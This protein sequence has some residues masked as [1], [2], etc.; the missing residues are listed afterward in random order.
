MT[1]PDKFSGQDHPTYRY[2][3]P[4]KDGLWGIYYPRQ[5]DD[6]D[7]EKWL[8]QLE[9]QKE[10]KAQRD[11]DQTIRLKAS[12]TES[13][14]DSEIRKIIGD[15]KN[16]HPA[17][18]AEILKRKGF[19]DEM[20]AASDLVYVE[21]YQKLSIKVNPDLAGVNEWGNGLTNNISGILC[22]TKNELGQ[23]TGWQIRDEDPNAD[24]RYKWASSGSE[25]NKK[26]SHLKNG[27]L[28]LSVID[29]GDRSGI[30]ALTEGVR[31]KT[32]L[33]SNRLN[34]CSIGAAG[35]LHYNS[36]RQ[37]KRALE[38]LGASIVWLSPDAGMLTNKGVINKYRKTIELIK[39]WGYIVQVL[40]WEQFNKSDGD[41]D[42][43][44]SDRLV[45]IQYLDPLTF[46]AIA[47]KE[48]WKLQKKTEYQT[49]KSFTPLE[50]VT[51]PY[52]SNLTLPNLDGKMLFINSPLATGKTRLILNI[53][54]AYYR[55][56]G[57]FLLG[58]RNGLLVQ[59][60]AKSDGKIIHINL[61]K[62]EFN[63]NDN[64]AWL[65]ACVDSILKVDKDWWKGK[66]IVIDEIQSV[67]FHLLFSS[68]LNNKRYEV[69]ER[70]IHAIT[71]AKGVLC[72]DGHLSDI[73]VN[74]FK[75][76]CTNKVIHTI[77]NDFVVERPKI[78]FLEGS[79][80]NQKIKKNDRS[81]WLKN[82]TDTVRLGPISMASDSKIFLKSMAQ[83]MNELGYKGLLITSETVGSK[84]VKAFLENPSKW[85]LE[86]NP[87][88]IFYSPTAESG[89]DISSTESAF[90]DGY[91]KSFYSFYFG[92]V[93][94]DTQRQMLMRLR[95][96]T[97]PRY[98]WLRSHSVVTDS[99]FERNFNKG[100]IL[101]Y[102]ITESNY[103]DL[104]NSAEILKNLKIKIEDYHQSI[105]QLS[106]DFRKI[107]EH[108]RIMFRRCFLD[109]VK[110]DGYEVETFTPESCTDLNQA[111]KAVSN[112]VKNQECLEIF[113]ASDKYQN[114]AAPLLSDN[115]SLEDRRAFEKASILRML[116][117][118]ELDAI[119]S[120]EFIRFIRFD[121]F[122][123]LSQRR[124]YF[125]AN[126]LDIAKRL[127]NK[128]YAN[129]IHQAGFCPWELKFEYSQAR[130]IAASGILDLISDS[131]NEP[132][133]SDH[134]SIKKI[135]QNCKKSTVYKP[136]GRSPGKDAIKF[137]SW[138]LGLLGYRLKSHSVNLNGTTARRYFLDVNDMENNSDYFRVID[139]LTASRLEASV[140]RFESCENP[141]N[142][143]KIDALS[144]GVSDP[145]LSLATNAFEVVTDHTDIFRKSGHDLQ[146]Q[147]QSNDP[148]KCTTPPDLD[149]S[150]QK[151]IS[152]VDEPVIA[153]VSPAIDNPSVE[154][155]FTAYSG[156]QRVL[157]RR[158]FEGQDQWLPATIK[159]V[160]PSVIHVVADCGYGS[161]IERHTL[162]RI[163]PMR[164]TAIAS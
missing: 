127:G 113:N 164:V 11:L 37:L 20:I 61:D 70:F 64:T 60:C 71:V 112:Q 143:L 59:T 35:G 133:T 26:S 137:V 62:Q 55:L 80:E 132:L 117:G 139:R 82:L 40:W 77:K 16:N 33:A 149:F 8:N 85:I 30:V 31:L 4:T 73:V 53:L 24:N 48:Q 123:I 68:T 15:L 66:I 141:E 83:I 148:P 153:I 126:N 116:P 125:M 1:F 32:D 119:W 135:I 3:K 138:L 160:N 129:Y 54:D 13:E 7:R 100:E 42:E 46:F 95:D 145:P 51:L 23:Y 150:Q 56:N 109:A 52:I 2:V 124:R 157:L 19:S 106:N 29:N 79:I 58:S 36:P 151:T 25:K 63:D 90:I 163:A 98:V 111:Y 81:P 12:L 47:S 121:R 72:L 27:E 115:A 96:I 107:V 94:T 22:F 101:S 103:L 78:N 147:N 67:L 43:I 114:V 99:N 44:E 57:C 34:I 76:I 41:I 155:P 69:I 108:E 6:F 45:S 21:K 89:L 102:L 158:Y 28:P 75:G 74:F 136:L 92:V 84:E 91:F 87:R 122:G 14:R 134:P 162:S 142:I 118:V 49:L 104:N 146:P 128:R 130:A 9:E 97:C 156:G 131:A 152:M 10:R 17:Q 39:S 154:L 120:P 50:S 5:D 93:G 144:F 88:Y 140:L 105:I 18:K 65:A 110:N 161:Y 38:A 159:S 86:N